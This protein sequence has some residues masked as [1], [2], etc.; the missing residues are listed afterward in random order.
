MQST[1]TTEAP[2]KQR[3]WFQQRFE[4]YVLG[5]GRFPWNWQFRDF[6]GKI[7][8]KG[9]GF[10]TRSEAI[11]S[12]KYVNGSP[13]IIVA[14]ANGRPVEYVHGKGKH[15]IVLAKPDG[16]VLGE[17]YSP[18]SQESGAQTARIEPANTF[19]DTEH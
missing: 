18:P 3:K 5:K 14:D 2:P 11:M 13:E 6:N 16:K 17:L 10:A 9:T 7:T 19:N 4:V 12:A 15:K 1:V 8:T